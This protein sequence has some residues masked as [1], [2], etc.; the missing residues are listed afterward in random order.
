MDKGRVK[1]MWGTTGSSLDSGSCLKSWVS[2]QGC[3]TF[4]IIDMQEFV[5]ETY[6]F[7]LYG[8]VMSSKREFCCTSRMKQITHT[9]LRTRKNVSCEPWSSQL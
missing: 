7:L 5:G 3:S 8:S 1:P 4:Q 9:L 2:K 6:L